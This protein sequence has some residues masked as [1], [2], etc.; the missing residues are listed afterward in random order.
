VRAL[1]ANGD[2]PPGT[3]ALAVPGTDGTG[4]ELV[5][6]ED[7]RKTVLQ[8]VEALLR[9][10]NGKWAPRSYVDRAYLWRWDAHKVPAKL[11]GKTLLEPTPDALL[12]RLTR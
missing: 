5:Q 10:H 6:S 12:Q 3:Q 11:A 7:G 4:A 2:L 9:A 1:Q 8:A